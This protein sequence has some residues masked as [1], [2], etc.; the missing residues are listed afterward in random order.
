MN[1]SSPIFILRGE[2]KIAYVNNVATVLVL[3]EP[4][5]LQEIEPNKPR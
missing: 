5:E 2:R 3:E 4:V 1:S